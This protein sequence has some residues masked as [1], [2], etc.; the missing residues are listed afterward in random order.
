MEYIVDGGGQYPQKKLDMGWLVKFRLDMACES[1][2]LSGKSRLWVVS[3]PGRAI[4]ATIRNHF[5]T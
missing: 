4:N 3:F 1:A 5:Q 2:G